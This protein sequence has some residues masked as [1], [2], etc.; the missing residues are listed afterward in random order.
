MKNHFK[1][2]LIIQLIIISFCNLQSQ[3]NLI[4]PD[5][6]EAKTFNFDVLNYD[7]KLDLSDYRNKNVVGVC[8][9][10]V[11]RNSFAK[12]DIFPVHIKYLQIND[13]TVGE[14]KISYKLYF[15]ENSRLSFYGLSYPDDTSSIVEFTINYS[16]TMIAEQEGTMAWGGVHYQEGTL[17]SMGVGFNAPYVSTTRHWMP[18]FDHPQDKATFRG[19]FVVPSNLTIAS[20]GLQISEKELDNNLKEFVWEQKLPSATY[21]MNFSAGPYK[22]INLDYKLPV[23]IYCLPADSIASVFSYSEVPA[24]NDCFESLFGDY[25]FEKIGYCNTT[26][27]A[28]EHQTMISMPRSLIINLHTF[29]NTN[30]VTAAHELAHQWFG[31]MVTPMDFRDAW[32]NESFATFCESLWMKCRNGEEAYF[33]DQIQKKNDY[34]KQVAPIEGI[35][36]L[37][38]FDRESPSSNYPTTIYYK[39]AVVLGMMKYYSESVG[40]DFIK[41]LKSY[42]DKFRLNQNYGN[43][44]I[45]TFLNDLKLNIPNI[46]WDNFFESWVYSAGWPKIHIEFADSLDGKFSSNFRITQIQSSKIFSYVPVEIIFYKSDGTNHIQ[47]FDLNLQVLDADLGSLFNYAIDSIKI[48]L[49]K[50]VVG[51]FE[52]SKVSVATSIENENIKFFEYWQSD[53]NMNISYESRG[54]FAILEICDLLGNIV[55]SQVYKAGENFNNININLDNFHSN[56][57]FVKFVVDGK[58]HY[59]KINIVK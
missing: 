2:L 48:N 24:M 33:V 44:D 31:N 12:E 40:V 14:T 41:Y 38:D 8:K 59:K 34:I 58:V 37:Y 11:K 7:V 43:S 26:K 28:M 54:D 50:E 22:K 49:G 30:N 56:V 35:L 36:P 23:E 32:L 19:T 10:L 52:L 18:C 51:L 6:L 15:P 47:V 27:G 25:P 46:N 4:V 29:K 21:L 1:K 17:Y 5:P 55:H 9:I 42:L 16:G 39:G 13:V 45:I 57:Y 53:K 20:N 3:E